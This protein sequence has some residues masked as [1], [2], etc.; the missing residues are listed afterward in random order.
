MLDPDYWAIIETRIGVG[1]LHD[2]AESIN[3]RP[4]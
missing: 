1:K 2:L 3:I 4:D